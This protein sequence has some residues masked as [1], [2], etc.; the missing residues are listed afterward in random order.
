VA[1]VNTYGG[2]FRRNICRNVGVLLCNLQGFSLGGFKFLAEWWLR[3]TEGVFGQ[4]LAM[5]SL[6][7][8]ARIPCK[9]PT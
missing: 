7:I 2:N 6:D 9:I 1:Y 5:Q 8:A 4:S 3:Q